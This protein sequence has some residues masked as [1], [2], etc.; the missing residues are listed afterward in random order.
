M[1]AKVV[2]IEKNRQTKSRF[3]VKILIKQEKERND[4]ANQYQKYR[5]GHHYRSHGRQ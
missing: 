4:K 5:R 1:A 3:F 2:K